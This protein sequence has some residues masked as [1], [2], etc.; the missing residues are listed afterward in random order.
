MYIY[1]Y[2]CIYIYIGIVIALYDSN[3][4]I[5]SNE[6]K[7]TVGGYLAL[8]NGGQ[9]SDTPV[10]IYLDTLATD[11]ALSTTYAFTNG[12][13]QEDVCVIGCADGSVLLSFLTLPT[14]PRLLSLSIADTLKSEYSDNHPETDNLSGQKLEA[15]RASLRKSSVAAG[16]GLGSGLDTTTVD[17]L[18]VAR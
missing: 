14:Q 4:N 16:L 3:M 11:I 9:L 7:V 2:I 1:T 12:D 8:W 6:Q 5:F 15:R 13:S 17:V 10:I 18:D